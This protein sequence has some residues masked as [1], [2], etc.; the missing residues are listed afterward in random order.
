MRHRW[1]EKVV[2][3]HK[4]ERECR[5]GCGIVKVGRS[6]SEGGRAVYWS[7]FWR[8]GE[9]IGCAGTPVCEPVTA[10]VPS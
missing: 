9:K 3:P 6:E 1:G 5:N 8:D 7:E 10:E 2:F 4:S